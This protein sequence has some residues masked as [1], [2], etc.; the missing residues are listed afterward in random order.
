MASRDVRKESPEVIYELRKRAVGMKLQGSTHEEIAA[1]LDV[2]VAASRLWWRI[3]R[4]G[5]EDGLALGQRGRP[6]GT[7][8][9]L[10]PAQEKAV[11]KAIA[12]K[13][14]DQLKMDF[15]L[16]TRPVIAQYILERYG[17]KLPVRTLGNYLKRWGFTPQRP[18]K[19]AYEQ[20]PGAVRAWI[21]H[22]YP[23]IARRAKAENA[24][25]LWGDETGVSNQDHAGRGFAPKGKTPVARGVAKRVT[26]SM[27][28]AI[29][30][31]GDARFMI[32]KGGLKSAT[33]IKFLTRLIK[34][35][36]RKIF[37]IVDNLRVHKAKA[38]LAWVA[39]RAERIE[40]FHLPSYSPELNPDEYLNNTVKSKMRNLKVASTQDELRAQLTKVMKSTQQKRELIRNL[41][42]HPKVAYA[43]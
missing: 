34:R 5:G 3:Y 33:F 16:W 38:V 1:N 22:S 13:T 12:D 26:T 18:K 29:G 20:Q 21:D 14:P 36:R 19:V 11:Q 4:D 9:T 6:P 27:I 10:T 15:A 39:E 43:A 30:N 8:R 24:E 25:I 42:K 28:S 41:F 31:R 17:I 32:Y 23:E 2:S 40:L 37:L 35:A 7:C